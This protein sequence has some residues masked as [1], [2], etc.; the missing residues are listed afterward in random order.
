MHLNDTRECAAGVH[1]LCRKPQFAKCV[2]WR[3]PRALRGV[4]LAVLAQVSGALNRPIHRVSLTP[5]GGAF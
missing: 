4:R 5:A 1:D 2:G 3:T